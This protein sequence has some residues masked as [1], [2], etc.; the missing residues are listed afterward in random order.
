MAASSYFAAFARRVQDTSPVLMPPRIPI[1][2][3]EGNWP[4]EFAPVAAAPPEV[5]ESAEPVRRPPGSAA[6][7]AAERRAAANRPELPAPDPREL[8][9]SPKEGAPR[10]RRA[11]PIVRLAAQTDSAAAADPTSPSVRKETPAA[12]PTSVSVSWVT[13]APLPSWPDAQGS[14]PALPKAAPAGTRPDPIDPS[15]HASVKPPPRT[16]LDRPNPPETKAATRDISYFP[17]RLGPVPDTNPSRGKSTVVAQSPTQPR[18]ADTANALAE[19]APLRL[20]VRAAPSSD[21]SIVRQPATQSPR[22]S[23][24]PLFAPALR[25][26][27]EWV[28][29]PSA[30]A[31]ATELTIEVAERSVAVAPQSA[32]SDAPVVPNTRAMPGL[33]SQSEWDIERRSISAGRLRGDHR[34]IH[35]G[36]I[37][38][39][40]EL[41]PPKDTPSPLQPPIQMAAPERLA[42][43]RGLARGFTTPL[44]LRQG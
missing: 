38:V 9:D 25:A 37:E 29:Q 3:W 40:I 43:V 7:S 14:Q 32:T 15:P 17:V 41:P 35:I 31:Q 12:S 39:R 11:A 33:A 36:S 34:E 8:A 24:S 21:A 18:R 2:G 23:P 26:A 4:A 16:T 1:R 30:K 10:P 19:P 28:V 6:A 22:L 27:L 44:G 5:A 20:A 42:T 13:P